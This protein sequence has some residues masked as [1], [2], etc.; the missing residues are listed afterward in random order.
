MTKSNLLQLHITHEIKSNITY[1]FTFENSSMISYLYSN[2][3]LL[4]QIEEN[5]ATDSS[6]NCSSLLA[7]QELN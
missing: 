1:Y 3:V 2:D 5:V 7:I 6:T 4:Y